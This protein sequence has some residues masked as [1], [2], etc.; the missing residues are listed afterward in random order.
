MAS[1]IDWHVIT[2]VL[3]I[4]SMWIQII[5]C[6]V[7]MENFHQCGDC[8]WL[9]GAT[10]LECQ[11][12]DTNETLNQGLYQCFTPDTSQCPYYKAKVPVTYVIRFI[13]GIYFSFYMNVCI[14][15]YSCTDKCTMESNVVIQLISVCKLTGPC[16][17]ETTKQNIYVDRSTKGI[18][19][20]DG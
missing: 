11:I 19:K 7:A 15:Q 12:I 14:S 4:I 16:L 10:S 5:V 2:Q 13:Y 8:I 3:Y 20:N 6:F 1:A 9:S 18:P 17:S